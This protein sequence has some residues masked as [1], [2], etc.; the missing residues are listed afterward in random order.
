[1]PVERQAAYP[2]RRRDR[3]FLL[4]L[5]VVAALAIAA[6]IAYAATRGGGHAGERCFT[7]TYPSSVGGA[8]VHRCGADAVTYCLH[9]ANVSQIAA[10]CRKEGF[11][12]GAD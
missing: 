9:D 1:V 6:G 3:R 11:R 5:G 2:L 7:A 10:A 4:A 12:V 8:T